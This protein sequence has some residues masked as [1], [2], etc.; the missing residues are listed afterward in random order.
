MEEEANIQKLVE[1]HALKVSVPYVT[2]MATA[3]SI[4]LFCV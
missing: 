1:R 4:L 3:I 2:I